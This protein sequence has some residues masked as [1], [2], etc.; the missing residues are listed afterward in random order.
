MTREH[1]GRAIAR[2]LVTSGAILAG[3]VLFVAY[4]VWE[5]GDRSDTFTFTSW[6][7][8]FNFLALFGGIARTAADRR[9]ERTVAT[10]A[11]S[12]GIVF[13]YNIVALGTAALWAAFGHD[14]FEAR[15]YYTAVIAE[16]GVAVAALVLI[17]TVD[18]AEAGAHQG[19][20]RVEASIDDLMRICA[21]LRTKSEID[22][23]GVEQELA[24]L[25]RRIKFSEALR[26]DSNLVY[27]VWEQLT[28]LDGAS[29]K[30]ADPD[31]Q[32]RLRRT[33]GEALAI[34]KQRG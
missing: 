11:S 18:L 24:E 27:R 15:H 28:G 25:G 22:G 10:K 20:T 13:A 1:S 21:S 16:T 17:R 32:E 8:A 34:A 12:V 7:V 4:R 31:F 3:V 29:A 2:V 14:L 26:R 6:F 5:P 30:A 33:L 9:G 23:W 19:A